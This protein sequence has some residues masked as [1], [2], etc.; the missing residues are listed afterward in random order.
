MQPIPHLT[1]AFDVDGTIETSNGPIKVERMEEL[2]AHGVNVV[3][4]SPSN[5]RPNGF[6]ERNGQARVDDLHLTKQDFPALVYL[7]VSDNGD[8]V[9]AEEAG[10]IYVD[11]LAFR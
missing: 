3:I 6:H 2:R 11:R 5:L 9:A 10:F 1:I 8:T 4:V 7:Y